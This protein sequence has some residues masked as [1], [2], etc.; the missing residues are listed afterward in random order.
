MA[1][2][3]DTGVRPGQRVGLS[4]AQWQDQQSQHADGQSG[5]APVWLLGSGEP[6]G[7][8]SGRQEGLEARVTEGMLD[9]AVPTQEWLRWDPSGCTSQVQRP[10]G[11]V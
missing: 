7:T 4:Q 6:E 9:T 3:R 1:P 5:K 11:T 2:K 10:T 8:A